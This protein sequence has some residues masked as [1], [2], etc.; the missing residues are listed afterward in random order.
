MSDFDFG[1]GDARANVLYARH[2]LSYLADHV[3]SA[4]LN[5]GDRVA[6]SDSTTFKLWLNELSEEARK[7]GQVA[8]RTE[9]GTREIRTGPKV[10]PQK[11][12]TADFCPRLPTRSRR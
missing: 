12:W 6:H 4:E 3:Y 2:L 10:A 5:S 8:L 7:R 1:P 11:R 9:L